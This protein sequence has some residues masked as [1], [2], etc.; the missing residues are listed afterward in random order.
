MRRAEGPWPPTLLNTHSPQTTSILPLYQSPGPTSHR[1]PSLSLPAS[2]RQA[3]PAQPHLDDPQGFAG[4]VFV[5]VIDVPR[6]GDAEQVVLLPQAAQLLVQNVGAHGERGDDR[7]HIDVPNFRGFVSGSRKQMSAIRTPTNLLKQNSVPH[8][9]ISVGSGLRRQPGHSPHFRAGRSKTRVGGIRGRGGAS[10]QAM[11]PTGRD[12]EALCHHP[13]L[14]LLTANLFGECKQA[15]I[16]TDETTKPSPY[17]QHKCLRR[18]PCP[19]PGRTRSLPSSRRRCVSSNRGRVRVTACISAVCV[20]SA[21]PGHCSVSS[22][23]RLRELLEGSA[24]FKRRQSRVS[25]ALMTARSRWERGRFLRSYAEI[26][27]SESV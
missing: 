9:R 7:V 11:S 24:P 2:H 6:Q 25:H 19:R 21:L 18:E 13:T 27:F 17:S 10:V 22:R 16:T 8:V 12:P 23:L 14:K 26:G 5:Q 1:P 3:H 20:P 4:I 15:T